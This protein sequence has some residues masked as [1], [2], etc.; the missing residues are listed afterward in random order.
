[1]SE[2]QV[3]RTVSEPSKRH[4]IREHP[5]SGKLVLLVLQNEG[6]LTSKEIAEETLLPSG[7]V[8][9]AL[10]RLRKDRLVDAEQSLRDGRVTV[11]EASTGI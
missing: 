11:Y 4:V 9:Q 5:P 6:R 2:S 3:A 7:T 1:M 8:R 10:Q